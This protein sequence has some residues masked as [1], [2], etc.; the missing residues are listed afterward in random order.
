METRAAGWDI[1]VCVETSVC[2]V[3]RCPVDS[4]AINRSAILDRE[5]VI[6]IGACLLL[7]KGLRFCSS[8]DALSGSGSWE[9]PIHCGLD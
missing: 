4:S 9:V 5:G 7:G 6:N 1:T 8:D 2:R 3:P